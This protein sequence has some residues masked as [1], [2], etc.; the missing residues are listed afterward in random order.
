[1]K[2]S[3]VIPTYN[4]GYRIADTIRSVLEQTHAP[5]EVIVVDD[6]STDDTPAVCSV[7]PPSVRYVRQANSGVAT[8]RN[9]GASLAQG[10]AIAFID[11]DDF[12]LPEKLAVQVA[13]LESDPAVGWVTTAYDVMDAD[14]ERIPWRRGFAGALPVFRA[15]GMTPEEFFGQYFERR[16]VQAAGAEHTWFAGDAWYPLFLGNFIFPS[17]VMIRR[18]LF[19]ESGGFDRAF[20]V[21]QDTEY[22]HRISARSPIGVVMTPLMLYRAASGTSLSFRSNSIELVSNALTSIDRAYRLRPATSEAESHY[23][24]GRRV[25]LRRLA[26]ANLTQMNGPEARRV[27]REGWQ[28]GLPRDAWTLGVYA[29]SL[30]PRPALRLLHGAKRAFRRPPGQ[31]TRS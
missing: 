1:M 8:A 31:P 19:R 23:R 11:S 15:V 20:R 21:A 6:G 12:W 18:D 28:W 25:L 4:R 7:M 5:L 10:D 26:Y 14:G 17:A 9:H 16:T 29:A 30:L 27:L 3:V 24:R 2:V 13:V 22:F